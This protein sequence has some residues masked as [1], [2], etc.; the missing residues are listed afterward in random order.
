M[1]KLPKHLLIAAMI[2]AL[3]AS[4][5]LAG[6]GRDASDGEPDIPA[7]ANPN[8]K[9]PAEYQGAMQAA[10]QGGQID[11]GTRLSAEQ[12]IHWRIALKVYLK[13]VRVFSL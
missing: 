2:A 9:T 7:I 4:S 5:A 12:P 6:P 13:L 8:G 10:V 1:S 3:T 11:D